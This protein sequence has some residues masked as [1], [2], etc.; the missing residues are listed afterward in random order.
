MVARRLRGPRPWPGRLA[1]GVIGVLVRVRR[2]SGR[3]PELDWICRAAALRGAAAA[4]LDPRA[5]LFINVEPPSNRIRVPGRPRRHHHHRRPVADRREIT[6]RAIAGDPDGL[7]TTVEGL[8]HRNRHVALD[9][10]G[11]DPASQAMMPLLRPDVIKLDQT[12]VAD[13]HTEH[14]QAVIAAVQAE[15]ARGRARS[16]WPKASK[17]RPTWPPPDRSARPSARASCSAARHRCR[18]ASPRPRSSGRG[19][20]ACR[21][22]ARRRSTPPPPRSG[23]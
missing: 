13:P 21:R 4:D 1:L 17:P 7:L 15:A 18:T 11:A 10:V 22:P 14:A 12:I 9:D 19:G 5:A 8:R 20:A 23:P 6:E 16:S 3:L 2:G